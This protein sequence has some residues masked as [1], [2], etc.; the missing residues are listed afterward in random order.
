MQF[1]YY[2][3]PLKGREMHLGE[4]GLLPAA[5]VVRAI[6]DAGFQNTPLF[7]FEFAKQPEDGMYL[8]KVTRKTDGL[9]KLVFI[10]TRSLVNYIWVE[11]RDDDESNEAEKQVVEAIEN[12]IRPKAY[13]YGWDAHV[14][15][16]V[17]EDIKDV[18]L[19]PR[20]VA[21]VNDCWRDIAVQNKEA[22]R[23]I[24]I[25]DD[26]VDDVMALLLLYMKGKNAPKDIIEPLRA[27]KEAGAIKKVTKAIFRS[28]F[29]DV[30]GNSIS[31]IDKYMR[32]SYVGYDDEQFQEM[33]GKF[34]ELVKRVGI[35]S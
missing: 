15:V 1:V 10:D 32:Q 14:C 29:G 19:L 12:A 20:A 35:K 25:A 9:A 33:K 17:P 26:I 24:V 21:Y 6:C 4:S 28:I 13:D 22:F 8:L 18:H 5:E 3:C 23:T 30:L 31:A 16:Y 7:D 34:V 2:C 11:K 27:A